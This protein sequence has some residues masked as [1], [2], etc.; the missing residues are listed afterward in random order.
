MNKLNDTYTRITD[1]IISKLENAG[2]WKKLWDCPSPISLKGRCYNG[3]NFLLLSNDDFASPVYGTFQQIRE[4]GG[5]VRKNEKSTVVVFWK[6]YVENEGTVDEEVKY[7]LRYYNVFNTDQADFDDA[8]KD[9]IKELSHISNEHSLAKSQKAEQ[10]IKNMPMAPSILHIKTDHPC[11]YPS[12]DKVELPH[13]QFF[14]NRDAY[15]N[16][17]FHELIHSTGHSTRLGRFDFYKDFDESDMKNY[18][19]EELVAEIGAS[20][21]AAVAGIDSNINNSAAYIKGWCSKLSENARWIVWASSR[22]AKATDFI[23]DNC[24]VHV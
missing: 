10:I 22:A 8:G 6:R 20:Y 2:S 14:A 15:Y 17:L 19:R 24:P 1:S 11:Y 21:L 23:L 18:S 12:L 3:I 9:R 16:A 5:F 13:M 4:N 7:F